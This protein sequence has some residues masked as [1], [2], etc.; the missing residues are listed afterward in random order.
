MLPKSP[1]TKLVF[2]V[3]LALT[4]SANAG[5]W[6][7]SLVQVG[8]TYDGVG[9]NPGDTLVL[10]IQYS[11]GDSSV[12]L[13]APTITWDASVA[14]FDGGSETGFALWSD[15]SVLLDAIVTGDIAQVAPNLAGGWD[16]GTTLAGGATA[17]CVAG[18]CTSL[19]TA[20]FTLSGVRGV[21]GF[22][23]TDPV[24][25][26]PPCLLEPWFCGTLNS[27]TVIPE[28]ATAGLL[29]V[30]LLALALANRHRER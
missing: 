20:S 26:V 28:P 19:G 22:G 16:K 25:E 12:I 4:A 8:G 10:D 14:S 15:G 13:I 17:P 27:F 3:G 2:L 18:A 21:I 11:L 9:A 29:G 24:S 5:A 30:G 1:V 7:L 6:T 23:L